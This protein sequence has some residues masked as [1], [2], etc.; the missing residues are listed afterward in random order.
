MTLL[1]KNLGYIFFLFLSC[2]CS[3]A[4]PSGT[5]SLSSLSRDRLYTPC[6]GSAVLVTGPPGKSHGLHHF[7]QMVKVSVTRNGTNHMFPDMMHWEGTNITDVVFL[8]KMHNMKHKITGLYCSQ[9]SR[10]LKTKTG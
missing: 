6:S 4:I 3:S 9:M 1:W 10:S 8:P 7:K 2:S 5:W